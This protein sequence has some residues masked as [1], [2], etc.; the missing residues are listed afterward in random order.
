[1][2]QECFSNNNNKQNNNNNDNTGSSSQ[3]KKTCTMTNYN[4]N[5]IDTDNNN[6]GIAIIS[7][8]FEICYCR[9]DSAYDGG[10]TWYGPLF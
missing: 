10:D 5:R 3:Q 4:D 1:M 8:V 7:V 6:F 9:R 2:I